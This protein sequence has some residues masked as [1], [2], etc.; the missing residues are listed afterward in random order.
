MVTF[1]N[2]EHIRVKYVSSDTFKPIFQLSYDMAREQI[3]H[4]II[5]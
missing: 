3:F 1:I 4:K 5:T 2:D